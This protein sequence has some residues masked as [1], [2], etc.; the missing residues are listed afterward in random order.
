MTKLRALCVLLFL[1]LP[2]AVL[3]AKNEP[4]IVMTW[5]ADKPALKLTFQKFR[6]VGTY[7]GQTS[8][9]SD[10]TVENMTEK[11]IPRASFTVYF[12]DK[13]KV[14]IGEGSLQV[15]DLE[16]GQAAKMQFQFN[17]VGI[18]ASITLSAKKDMLAAPG[19][20]TIPL[21]VISVPP[22]AKLKVDGQEVG[23]TPVMVRLTV[24]THQLDLTKEG[25]APGGTPLD[26]TPDELPGGSITVELGGLSRDTVELR[27]GSVVL[28]DVISLSMTQ[29]LV[30][31]DGKDQTYDRNQVKKI[32]LVE[33]EVTQQPPVT[34]P[35][36]VPSHP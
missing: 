25:Y 10:V 16:A 32:M 18:P 24:G 7:G 23:T 30:R 9:V 2:S 8:F 6:Q 26:V 27:D 4:V 5:P 28:G 35:V 15:S 34:Q 1:V 36:P 3:L 13:N 17:S 19:P 22:G 12:M 14:R 21:R 29:V 20:K 11:Q 33:R 31:V